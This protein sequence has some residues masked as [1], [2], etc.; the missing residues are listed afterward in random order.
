VAALACPAATVAA[1]SYHLDPAAAPPS[2]CS[3]ICWFLV[4]IT[5]NSQI[6]ANYDCSAQCHQDTVSVHAFTASWRAVVVMAVSQNKAT[7]TLTIFAPDTKGL[8]SIF[9]S[10]VGAYVRDDVEFTTGLSCV[11]EVSTG[12]AVSDGPEYFMK[13]DVSLH[14][15]NGGL[16]VDPGAVFDRYFSDQLCGN[17]GGIATN[18]QLG[19][20][21]AGPWHFSDLKAPSGKQLADESYIFDLALDHNIDVHKGEHEDVGSNYV[22]LTFQRFF[23]DGSGVADIE[24]DSKQA[25]QL[26]TGYDRAYPIRSHGFKLIPS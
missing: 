6:N 7:K 12:T 17:A 20:G 23:V 14:F 26:E 2:G 9:A 16:T 24:S 21:L 11:K 10:R 13:S 5:A 1:A 15:V 25:H 4:T 18:G 19:D 8:D 22:Y 3:T